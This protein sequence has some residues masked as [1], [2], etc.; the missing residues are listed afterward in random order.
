M[1][2]S[3]YTINLSTMAHTV[4]KFCQIT[5][6]KGIPRLLRAKS[7]FMRCVWTIS[8]IGF[9]C[10]ALFQATL[11]TMEYFQYKTYTSTGEVTLDY[12][13][14]DEAFTVMPDFTFCN[15]NPFASNRSLN[16]DIPTKEEYLR[17]AEQST[18]C[19]N[20]CTM[21]EY[22]TLAYIRNE[23]MT[24]TGYFNFIGVNNAK[25]LGHNRESFIAYCQLEKEGG[26][27]YSHRV[28]CLPTAKIIDIHYTLLYKCY[29]I[30][31][32]PNEL[33]DK[34][35][36]G[37]LVVLHLDDY[38]VDHNEH[39]HLAPHEEPSQKSGVWFF[40]HQRGNPLMTFT[41]SEMLQ[42]GHYHEIP[43]K[44]EIRSLLP[45]PHGHCQ[46]VEG[47]EYSLLKCYTTC[48]Q[49]L[50]YQRCGCVD[51]QNYTSQWDPIDVM[52]PPCL[53]VTLGKDDLIKNWKCAFKTRNIGLT[54]ECAAFCPLP[55]EEIRY[56]LRVCLS[57]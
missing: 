45:P 30:R 46:S 32:P 34:L 36:G 33:P 53:S 55:C 24:T 16:K 31:L 9:L 47:E 52:G 56:N 51:L 41:S 1:S 38:D 15:T 19:R 49:R 8:V 6:V 10:M 29:T 39:L 28:P 3:S 40:A 14:K 37:V 35:Y 20:N 18:E 54:T 42:P 44:T 12:F 11:L 27:F 17:L 23:I 21:D 7:I 5:S 43:I 22:K 50:V 26:G 2:V 4:Y 48:I 13:G 57:L 25:R